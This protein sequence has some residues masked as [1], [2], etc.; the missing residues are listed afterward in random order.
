MPNYSTLQMGSQLYF[1]EKLVKL[2]EDFKGDETWKM[3]LADSTGTQQNAIENLVVVWMIPQENNKET[4]P[5][6][7][8]QVSAYCKQ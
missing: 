5:F 3:E 2:F 1:R 6:W 4:S 7:K 8:C